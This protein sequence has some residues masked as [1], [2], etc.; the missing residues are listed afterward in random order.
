MNNPEK[1]KK[2]T[3]QPKQAKIYAEEPQNR[4]GRKPSINPRNIKMSINLTI[5]EKKAIQASADKAGIK[6]AEFCRAAALKL[7]VKSVTPI[8]DAE[9]SLNLKKIGG[10]LKV[11]TIQNA[12]KTNADTRSTIIQINSLRAILLARLEVEHES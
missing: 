6:P 4:K 5:D 10:L 3:I 11:L 2:M 9:I 8:F 7:N 1:D 12:E